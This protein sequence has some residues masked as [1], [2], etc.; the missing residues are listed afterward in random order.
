MQN[1]AASTDRQSPWLAASCCLVLRSQ[2]CSVLVRAT[3]ST[4]GAAPDKAHRMQKRAASADRQSPWLA[5]PS[6][7]AVSSVQPPSP[8]AHSACRAVSDKAHRMQT[9]ARAELRQTKRTVCKRG[10]PLQTA[11]PLG[12]LHPA[13]LA[14]PPALPAWLRLP[15]QLQHTHLSGSVYVS[16]HTTRAMSLLADMRV[17][18]GQAAP[19]CM[20]GPASS[21]T[22][23]N[24]PAL[25][26]HVQTSDT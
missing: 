15:A 22:V 9:W 4:W 2:E 3:C 13:A 12:W 11:S 25:L 16:Q 8:Y 5:A 18:Q 19:R 26:Q 24:L 7:L 1:R 20:S 6:C 21:M 17:L 10:R 14:A 23:R